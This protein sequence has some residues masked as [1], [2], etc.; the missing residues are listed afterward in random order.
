MLMY[1]DIFH[2]ADLTLQTT[3]LLLLTITIVFMGA[4]NMHPGCYSKYFT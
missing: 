1:V 3:Y 2:V 4:C